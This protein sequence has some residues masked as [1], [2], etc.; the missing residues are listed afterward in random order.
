VTNEGFA[1]PVTSWSDSQIQ[2]ILSP[3]GGSYSHPIQVVQNGIAS[4]SVGFMVAGMEISSISP[5]S[6]PIGTQVTIAGANFG[7]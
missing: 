4:N 3:A 5:T 1:M 2:F 6:G 7:P